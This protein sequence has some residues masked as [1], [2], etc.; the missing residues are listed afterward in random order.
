MT[1][2]E[3]NIRRFTLSL[4]VIAFGRSGFHVHFR[5]TKRQNK[6]IMHEMIRIKFHNA[7]YYSIVKN[8]RIPTPTNTIITV[9]V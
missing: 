8:T 1:L 6:I 9:T 4:Y 3:F 5:I 2:S 7:Q